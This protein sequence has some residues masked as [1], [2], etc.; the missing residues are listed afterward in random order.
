MKAYRLML[1]VVALTAVALAVACTQKTHPATLG[2]NVSQPAASTG[3]SPASSAQ[4]TSVAAPSPALTT[5]T[6]KN[7]ATLTSI[8]DIVKALRPSVVRVRTDASQVGV[9]GNLQKASGTGT[10][11]I[12][13][14]DGHILTNN[15]VVT[16]GTN[17]PAQKFTVD[18]A[19]GES[20]DAQLVGREPNADLAILKISAKGLT[21]AR[22]ADPKSINVGDTVVAMG[23]ALD[24]G[25]QPSVTVGVVS[26]LGRTIDETISPNAG[27]VQSSSQQISIGGAIQTDAAINP[28]NSGGPLVNTRGEV[29]GINTAGI[30]STNGE[31]VQG[32]N[33]AVSVDTVLPVTK[34]LISTGRVDRGFLGVTV[35]PITRDVASAQH[36]PVNDGVGIVQVNKGSAADQAGLKAGD[37]IVKV[38]NIEVHG[39]G[40]LNEALIENGSGAKVPVTVYRGTDKQTVDVTLG[41]RPA[42]A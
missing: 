10:G 4:G 31:P 32:I 40:D 7:D 37:I 3:A 29:I 25:A 28:G 9:F 22:L 5:T 19:D 27:V 16:L 38:G 6:S 35:T 11:I 1:P 24:L 34:S 15:H 39:L 20:L 26:A 23:Y 30:F 13:D 12:L 17:Q 33:F 42:S 36:L 18:L 2:S 21:P 8:P 41:S 14:T